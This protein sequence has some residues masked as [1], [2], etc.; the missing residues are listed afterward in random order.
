MFTYNEALKANPTLRGALTTTES[1]FFDSPAISVVLSIY[2]ITIF[3]SLKYRLKNRPTLKII[4]YN[5]GLSSKWFAQGER[6]L[7]I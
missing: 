1:H 2:I 4:M 7:M 6:V 3:Y 5:L